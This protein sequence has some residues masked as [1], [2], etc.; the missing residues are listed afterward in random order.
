MPSTPVDRFYTG[1]TA[2]SGETKSMRLPETVPNRLPDCPRHLRHGFQ[3][4]RLRHLVWFAR[5]STTASPQHL[6]TMGAL[7]HAPQLQ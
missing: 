7:A 1:E 3:S 2:K 4:A 6:C 5:L